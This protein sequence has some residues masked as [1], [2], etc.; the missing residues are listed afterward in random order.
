M[1]SQASTI[2]INELANEGRMND[3]FAGS[4]FSIVDPVIVDGKFVPEE[5]NYLTAG[6]SAS[7]QIQPMTFV[8]GRANKYS[9]MVGYDSTEKGVVTFGPEAEVF[10]KQLVAQNSGTNVGETAVLSLWTTNVH[11]PAVG[12]TPE[13]EPPIDGYP[14][15]GFQITYFP[16]LK[17]FALYGEA[18]APYLILMYEPGPALA[19]YACLKATNNTD[20]LTNSKFCLNYCDNNPLECF[21]TLNDFC[22]TNIDTEICLNW[23]RTDPKANCN[24]NLSSYC[25]EVLANKYQND[26]D[27][28]VENSVDGP[29][30]ACFL[31]EG[32]MTG[33]S[34]SL[35]K[36]YKRPFSSG[37]IEC[38]YPPCAAGMYR[39]ET[40]DVIIPFQYKRLSNQCNATAGCLTSV[41]IDIA[42]KLLSPPVVNQSKSCSEYNGL[43]KFPS[44]AQTP[45]IPN[46]SRWWNSRFHQEKMEI[47]DFFLW[48]F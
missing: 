46:Y 6:I 18:K 41:S 7:R 10:G 8:K 37:T 23:C 12:W 3:I 9:R 47:Q 48:L 42:G 35:A 5:S 26:V 28:L 13:P 31:P 40:S 34:K 22:D 15:I 39:T 32:T 24:F 1:G 44:E 4:T 11:D 33:Y 38:Y 20:A 45:S 21:S 36:E 25:S 30:C 17:P 19:N 16:N 14:Q 27:K 43:K 2:A 29:T